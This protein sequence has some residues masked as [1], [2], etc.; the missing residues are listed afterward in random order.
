M[1]H[2]QDHKARLAGGGQREHKRWS[3]GSQSLLGSGKSNSLKVLEHGIHR[4]KATLSKLEQS[5]LACMEQF[6]I[7]RSLHIHDFT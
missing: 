4:M 3:L 7:L 5:S 2:L 6:A 1:C